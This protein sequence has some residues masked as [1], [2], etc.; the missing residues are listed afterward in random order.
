ME[1]ELQCIICLSTLSSPVTFPCSSH[2]VCKEPCLQQLLHSPTHA[3]PVPPTADQTNSSITLVDC[4][5]CGKEYQLAISDFERLQPNL[6][7][8]R[9]IQLHNALL[10]KTETPQ[11]ST[12]PTTSGLVDQQVKCE[13]CDKPATIECIACGCLLCEAHDQSIHSFGKLL[14]HP[15][16]PISVDKEVSTA[17]LCTIHGK[18][19]DLFCIQDNELLCCHCLVAEGSEHSTHDCKSIDYA[20]VILRARLDANK[21]K[22]TTSL[23]EHQKHLTE[24]NRV[25]SE[26]QQSRDTLLQDLDSKLDGIIELLQKK[27][28]TLREDVELYTRTKLGILSLEIETHQQQVSAP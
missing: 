18:V 28:A 12:T 20:A 9:I 1:A 6:S 8:S 13:A 4:P 11:G 10:T 23:Q 25:Q 22:L 5:I 21:F 27:K 16:F 19:K 26:I 2:S 17:R 7:L 24:L 14:K 15:R 3:H